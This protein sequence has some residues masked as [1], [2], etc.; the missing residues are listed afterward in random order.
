MALE[1]KN[2]TD[3]ELAKLFLA[4]KFPQTVYADSEK[5]TYQKFE[6]EARKN[7]FLQSGI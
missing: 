2:L 4:T 7:M 5:K 6:D 1:E 3:A